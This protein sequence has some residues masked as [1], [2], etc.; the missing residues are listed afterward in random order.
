Q[1]R[2]PSP[3]FAT[4]YYL[5]HAPD[6]KDAGVDP[7]L[8]YLEYGQNEERLISPAVGRNIAADGFDPE[9]YLMVNADVAATGV[10]PHQHFQTDGWH[11]GRDPNGFFS[12]TG[13][14]GI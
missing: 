10:D 9:Y 7:L 1:G 5:I 13:Y 12:T 14:L 4:S 11:E 8:H 6:V 3:W 2:N